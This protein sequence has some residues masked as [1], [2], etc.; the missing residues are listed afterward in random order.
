MSPPNLSLIFIMVCFWVAMWLV[1]RF[2]IQ[3]VGGVLAERKGRID[4]AAA[5]WEDTN[6][7]YL[8][9]TARLESE[10]EDAAREAARVRAEYRQQAL[11]RRQKALEESRSVADDRLGTALDELESATAT[12]RQELR[13]RAR[14]LA[15]V[16]ASR[17]LDRKVTS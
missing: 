5:K 13:D 17:L 7:Q 9:A 16:F 1:Y 14:E 8:D 2:L 10:T 11:D 12:A 15:K 4:G 6:Q 3:P